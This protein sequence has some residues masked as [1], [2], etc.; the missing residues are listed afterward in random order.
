MQSSIVFLCIGLVR[1][2]GGGGYS[3]LLA[4]QKAR[5]RSYSIYSD[6]ED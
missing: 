3:Q 2:E 6:D 4:T 5:L 1:K